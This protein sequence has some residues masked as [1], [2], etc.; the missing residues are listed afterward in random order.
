MFKR[1]I[2][3]VVTSHL[4]LAVV[5][6]GGGSRT[7]DVT[8]RYLEAWRTHD[9][10]TLTEMTSPDVVLE[11]GRGTLAGRE[12]II[13]AVEFSAGANTTVEIGNIVV[14]GDTVEFEMAEK[15]DIVTACGIEALLHHPRLI[16]EDGKLVRKGEVKG[17]RTFR[18]Y[19]EQ[20]SILRSWIAKSRPDILE[21]ITDERGRYKINRR[22]GEL[23]AMMARTWHESK[24]IE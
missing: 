13:N 19:A 5:S 22:T 2:R 10:K 4:A 11:F 8:A 3:I 16:F 6:C 15:N 14:R 12:H 1:L 18:V 24:T 20:L 17:N 9:I 23:L 7:D 21:A